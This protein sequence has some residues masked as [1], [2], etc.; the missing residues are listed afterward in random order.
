MTR[1]FL[2]KQI[3]RCG[4]EGKEEKRRQLEHEAYS[5]QYQTLPRGKKQRL[6]QGKRSAP[7]PREKILESPSPRKKLFVTKCYNIKPK[8]SIT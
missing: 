7:S 4:V 5:K 6:Q 3:Q 8:I 2:P 1:N